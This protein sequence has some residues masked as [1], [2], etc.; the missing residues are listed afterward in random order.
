MST[1]LEVPPPSRDENPREDRSRELLCLELP[2]VFVL[3]A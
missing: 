1:T 2:A 3:E